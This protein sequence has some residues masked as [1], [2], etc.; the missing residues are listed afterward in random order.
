MK[1]V[2]MLAVLLN[3][4]ACDTK[5]A[6]AREQEIQTFADP[7]IE[8]LHKAQAVQATLDASEAAHNKMMDAAQDSNNKEVENE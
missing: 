6:G 5:K 2:L 3:L 8:Q 1:Y 4:S 7:A